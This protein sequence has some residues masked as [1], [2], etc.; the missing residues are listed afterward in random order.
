MREI[1]FETVSAVLFGSI[2]VHWVL[3]YVMW[4][5][6]R[7]LKSDLKSELKKRI[8]KHAPVLLRAP[9]IEAQKDARGTEKIIRV[10]ISLLDNKF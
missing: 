8:A 1:I 5:D 10:L 7:E 4:F 9:S 6:L 2:T 3:I